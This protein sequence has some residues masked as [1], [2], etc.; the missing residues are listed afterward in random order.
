MEHT[1]EERGFVSAGAAA[2]R[3]SRSTAARLG[4]AAAGSSRAADRF[5]STARG[6]RRTAGNFNFAAAV[7]FLFEAAEVAVR[8]QRV[9]SYSDSSG[10]RMRLMN[11]G[12]LC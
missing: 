12:P 7:A 9:Y 6:F 1:A 8:K 11:S 10:V 5:R 4:S 2:T 3:G